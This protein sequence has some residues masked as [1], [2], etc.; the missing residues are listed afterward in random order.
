MTLVT[1]REVL[2]PALKNGYAVAGL[3][4]LGWEDMR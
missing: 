4:T 3:V 1:L 2:Q